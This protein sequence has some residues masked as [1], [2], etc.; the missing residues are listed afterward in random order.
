MTVRTERPSCA[1]SMCEPAPVGGRLTLVSFALSFLSEEA[2]LSP[3]F[4]S[5][6]SRYTA[7]M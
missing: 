3:P 1:A 2:L 7:A 5:I 6:F 4:P